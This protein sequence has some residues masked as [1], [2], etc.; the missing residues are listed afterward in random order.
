M[1]FQI[2][3]DTLDYTAEEAAFGKA[4]GKDLEEGKLTLPLIFALANC[5][6]EEKEAAQKAIAR[7]SLDEA[8]I[9]GIFTIIRSHDGIGYALNRAKRYVDDAKDSLASFPDGEAKEA[10]LAVAD[11]VIERKT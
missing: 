11:F 9:R 1:A 6:P 10:L 5:S 8:A 2:T 4:I 7:R 3:D